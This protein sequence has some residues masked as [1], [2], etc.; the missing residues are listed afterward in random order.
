MRILETLFGAD[1]IESLGREREALLRKAH[2]L[3]TKWAQKLIQSK[4]YH[5]I[6]SAI[7][8]K[9]ALIDLEKSSEEAYAGIKDA[10]EAARKLS[11]QAAKKIGSIMDA[12]VKE[13][14]KIRGA[15]AHFDGNKKSIGH[16]RKILEESHSRMLDLLHEAEKALVAGKR[17]MAEEIMKDVQK[18]LSK[19]DGKAAPRAGNDSGP[20]ET[21]KG[22][23]EELRE[24]FSAKHYRKKGRKHIP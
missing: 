2:A 15:K 16:V 23:I 17:Q 24:H 14:R 5:D 4:E 3:E 9:L 19:A 12:A 7:H 10:E 20:I 11:A 13:A 8:M 6:K 18:K 21:P 1:T 22:Q